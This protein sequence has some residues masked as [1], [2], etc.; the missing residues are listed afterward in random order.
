MSPCIGRI[1][2]GFR[3]RVSRILKGR[4]AQRVLDGMSVY[5]LL[6]KDMSEADLQE[7]ETYIALCHN[8]VS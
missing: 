6:V 4:K 8:T 3:H 5:P 2:G 1:L 7:G